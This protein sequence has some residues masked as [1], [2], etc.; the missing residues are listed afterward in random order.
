M[1]SRILPRTALVA[2]CA[3]L[4]AGCSSPAAAPPT[5]ATSVAVESG[6]SSTAA[7]TV[8]DVRTPAEYAEGHL[9]GAINIDLSAADFADRVAA[10]DPSAGYTV[11][12]RTGNRSAT[13]VGLMT[14]QGFTDVT[15]G[16]SVDDAAALT[17]LAVVGG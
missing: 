4:V 6:A 9:D 7:T 14:D 12:C 8:I 3:V 13:A 11:Y 10:L 1:S 16:G 5:P 2:A 15:D 17:G